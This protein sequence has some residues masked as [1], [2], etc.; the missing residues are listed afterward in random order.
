MIK[1]VQIGFMFFAVMMIMVHSIIPHHHH[2][3]TIC[4]CSSDCLHEYHN[5][6][7]TNPE[8]HCTDAEIEHMKDCDLQ[9]VPTIP[10]INVTQLI[11]EYKLG[12]ILKTDYAHILASSVINYFY[13]SLELNYAFLIHSSSG[14]RA[15]PFNILTQNA[16]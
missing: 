15:P 3:A 5:Y 11:T 6:D 10:R 14:L 8:H 9:H 7:H 16:H 4:F 12:I 2:I 13:I 1:K